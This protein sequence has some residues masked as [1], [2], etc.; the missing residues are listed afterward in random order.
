MCIPFDLWFALFEIL[1]KK[2]NTRAY[3]HTHNHMTNIIY[4][5]E[6]E[7]IYEYRTS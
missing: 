2:K 5:F 7:T 3:T 4:K 6:M 1:P